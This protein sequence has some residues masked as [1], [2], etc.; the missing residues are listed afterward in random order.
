[1]DIDQGSKKIN[2]TI[3][4]SKFISRY[5]DVT[6]FKAGMERL[7][8]K[9]R[10]PVP[11]NVKSKI[12][13]KGGSY[14]DKLETKRLGG[15]YGRTQTGA[16]INKLGQKHKKLNLSK[17]PGLAMTKK[18]KKQLLKQKKKLAKRQGQDEE[19][20][21]EISSEGSEGEEQS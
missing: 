9:K 20:D 15:Q 3:N 7:K 8:H 18:Q 1:M 19:E 4:E 13:S 5:T 21:E 6:G 17:V 14:G 12:I 2:T 16:A 10:A 11:L